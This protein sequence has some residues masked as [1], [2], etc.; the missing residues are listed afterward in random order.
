MEKNFASLIDHTML[1]PE[2]TETEIKKLCLEAIEYRFKSVCIPLKFLPLA[3]QLLKGKE[4]YPITV[5]GFPTGEESTKQKV[6]E[7]VKALALG[8]KE[9]DM[10]ISI[11]AL[12]NKDYKKVYEDIFHVVKTAIPYPVKV[13]IETCLLSQEEKIIACALAKAAGAAF[14]K[15]ST[16]F[17]SGGAT[18]EDVALMRN[19]VGKDM[20]VKA[21]GKI[22]TKED[23]KKMVKAGADRLGTSAS[24]TIIEKK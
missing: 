9:I 3:A 22:R 4:P 8:A 24:V 6:E 16:G 20:G 13:I 23:A 21:S 11:S 2:T 15:T 1:S 5:V 17:Q 7:T 18:V 19:I 10:V 14:V 12:K